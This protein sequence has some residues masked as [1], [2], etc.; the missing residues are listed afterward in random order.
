MF[1]VWP[2]KC[3]PSKYYFP[4]TA[5]HTDQ[6]LLNQQMRRRKIL[7]LFLLLNILNICNLVLPE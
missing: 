6:D 7:G 1:E 5:S 2:E 4:Q 3:D